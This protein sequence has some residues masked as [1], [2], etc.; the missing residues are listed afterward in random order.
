MYQHSPL[1]HPNLSS[2]FVKPKTS[3]YPSVHFGNSDS[4]IDD[5]VVIRP[6]RK[7]RLSASQSP[8]QSDNESSAPKPRR[9]LLVKKNT[10]KAASP[11]SDTDSSLSDPPS[12]INTALSKRTQ[13]KSG[14]KYEE[15]SGSGSD[16]SR[17]SNKRRKLTAQERN[18]PTITVEDAYQIIMQ[19]ANN[20][21]R[22]AMTNAV[23]ALDPEELLLT[24]P[25]ESF[26]NLLQEQ[27]TAHAGTFL[28]NYQPG[29]KKHPK[30]NYPAIKA[31]V[32][33]F[34]AEDLKA[35]H[36]KINPAAIPQYKNLFQREFSP[37]LLQPAQPNLHGTQS[38]KP[39]GL[40]IGKNKSTFTEA[41]STLINGK[42][43]SPPRRPNLWRLGR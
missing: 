20:D 40:E 42:V 41:E 28:Q 1:V 29:S 15:S 6:K 4:D 3:S 27:R 38:P 17:R 24:K 32:A 10:K 25:S 23:P 36:P 22:A 35:S 8:H 33:Q 11:F 9:R 30:K 16:S 39:S 2:S 34:L 37:S 12:S 43:T 18:Q 21:F 7:S 31:A 5:V 19:P 13:R 26:V 14:I